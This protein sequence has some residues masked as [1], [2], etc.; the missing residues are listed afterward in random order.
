MPSRWNPLII[1]GMHRSG[2]SLTTA[3]LG[4]LGVALG[5]RLLAGD[6]HNAKGYF[7]DL[8]F[9]AFQRQILQEACTPQEPGWP[10]W[11]WTE[12]ERL[13]RS[14]WDDPEIIAEA[15]AIV[16]R[17]PS[18]DLWGWK[19]PRTTLMLDFW[20]EQLPEAAFL[21]VYRLPWDVAD[22]VLRIGDPTFTK[23]PE[24]GLRAWAFY[25]QHLLAFYEANR[26]R[27]IL[28]NV[29]AFIEDPLALG[30]LLASRFDLT[31]TAIDAETSLQTIFDRSLF[32][33]LG[34]YDPLVQALTHLAPRYLALL[35]ALDAAADLPS[36]ATT[37][38]PE[39]LPDFRGYALP[40][41][42]AESPERLA[43]GL[44]W[45]RLQAQNREAAAVKIIRDQQGALGALAQQQAVIE[46][47]LAQARTELHAIKSSKAWRGYQRIKR[48]RP[49]LPWRS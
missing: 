44:H 48:L 24:Y 45:E 42:G 35:Q 37:I 31:G 15:Q 34:W 49:Q 22:S 7:E 46:Q 9:L 10:D 2:T 12:G 4:A 8:D 26:D 23:H 43:L 28:L 20:A 30:S 29:E 32:R 5:D 41:I 36:A 11:G 27:C 13:D 39:P 3:A 6:R 18:Q 16:A 33:S 19:D 14:R 17:R 1:T 21:L 25:N 40:A 38:W 47:E